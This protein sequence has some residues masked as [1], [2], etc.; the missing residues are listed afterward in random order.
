MHDDAFPILCENSRVIITP[1]AIFYS[2][3]T[4]ITEGFSYCILV[5]LI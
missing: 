4:E 3:F 1:T 5:A 2:L